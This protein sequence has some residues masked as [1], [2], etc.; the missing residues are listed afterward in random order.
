MGTFFKYLMVGYLIYLV[1]KYIGKLFTGGMNPQNQGAGNHFGKSNSRNE[2][3]VNINKRPTHDGEKHVSG[4]EYV[5]FEDV[6]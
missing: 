4:G 6:D 3:E 2:G 1:I 5:D